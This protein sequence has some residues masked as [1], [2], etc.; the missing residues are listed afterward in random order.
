MTRAARQII[1]G[2]AAVAVLVG[3]GLAL[4]AAGAGPAGAQG[5]AGASAT[6][7]DDPAAG[8]PAALAAIEGAD[9]SQVRPADALLDP[10][11][12]PD[13][14]AVVEPTHQLL[15]PT[16]GF[17]QAV[18]HQAQQVFAMARWTA[19]VAEVAVRW[20]LGLRVW[21]LLLDPA[22]RLADVVH[23]DL[24]GPLGL[25]ELAL[26]AVM[27]RTAWLV[28][29]SRA[30]QGGAELLTGLLLATAG[31]LGVAHVDDVACAGLAVLDDVGQALVV[32][33]VD[34]AAP[35]AAPPSPGGPPPTCGAAKPF[36]PAV[37]VDD[38]VGV[39]PATL[40]HGPHQLLQWGEVPAG[41]CA[42][43]AA[44]VRAR[45]A[46]RDPTVPVQ[47]MRDAGCEALADHAAQPD[48]ERVVAGVAHLSATGVVA[49]AVV[50][51][52]GTVLL[53][54]AGAALLVMAFPVVA[55]LGVAPAGGR[56]QLGRW[57][58]TAGRLAVSHLLGT[59]LLVGVL[60]VLHTVEAATGPDEVVLRL[61][62]A[63]VVGGAVL[64]L[65]RRAAGGWLAR[66][67]RPGRW[68]AGR[69]GRPAPGRALPTTGH[70]LPAPGAAASVGPPG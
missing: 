28:F 68:P 37:A 50:L 53:A 41:D 7:A 48:A 62:L 20:A 49:G 2:L 13:G 29:A 47:A 8:L 4:V 54:Q 6:A 27:A 57:V 51:L 31:T 46:W 67:G 56:R 26:L 10:L 35:P 25:V 52:A 34:G 44:A 40:V 66:G 65:H 14:A 24:L 43:L 33:V 58:A 12:S 21:R 11:R 64:A 70:G 42:T 1:S 30:A 61:G 18:G 17:G 45:G 39:I 15:G 32:L 3:M 5:T 9:A 36:G 38:L 22:Q 59:V 23:H 55:L 19:E 60:A 16:E 63:V 69:G